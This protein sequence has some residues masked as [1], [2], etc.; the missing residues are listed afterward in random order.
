MKQTT[1]SPMTARDFNHRLIDAISDAY[2]EEV[3]WLLQGFAA[4]SM[5]EEYRKTKKK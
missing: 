5:N 3:K 1:V 2:M 4:K